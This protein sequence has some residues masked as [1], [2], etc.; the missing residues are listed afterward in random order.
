[1]AEIAIVLTAHGEPTGVSV[2]GSAT[3]WP[4]CCLITTVAVS[5][6]AAPRS[7]SVSLAS[8]ITPGVLRPS[9]GT[10]TGTLSTVALA[11]A[12]ELALVCACGVIPAVH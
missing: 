4:G 7:S 9:S 10:M 11:P 3:N 8:V 1:M 12:V 2:G 5:G 6:H